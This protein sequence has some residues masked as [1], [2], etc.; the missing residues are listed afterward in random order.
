MKRNLLIVCIVIGLCIL[1][2][3]YK[4]SPIKYIDFKFN[5][6]KKYNKNTDT[7]EITLKTNSPKTICNLN[8][9]KLKIN[10]DKDKD[11][12]NDLD[13]ILQGARKDVLNKPVYK[14]TYYIG[15]YPP[16]NE[17]VCTDV[18]WRA[19]K[20]AG[21]NVKDMIDKDIKMNTYN[22]PRTLGKPDPNID[23][24]RVKN[25]VPFL[26]KYAKTLTNKVIP[27]N[28]ENLK[29]WQRG[30]IVVFVGYT[31]HIAIVSDVRRND[32]IPYIIHNDGPYT[33]EEDSLMT[34]YHNSKQVYH[35]RIQ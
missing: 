30:D 18:I 32:G 4:K 29:Q 19:L 16:D 5:V 27:Y 20:N 24:R 1:I 22:Y 7:S 15:G 34:W 11:N 13:D 31:D 17:G 23:F 12:I 2:F 35:F 26:K 25:L 8:I 14:S 6:L 33:E 10:K 21:Y 3:N 28:I 9:P